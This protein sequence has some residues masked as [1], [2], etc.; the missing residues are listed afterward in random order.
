[1]KN[2]ALLG[3]IYSENKRIVHYTQSRGRRRRNAITILSKLQ[4]SL[5]VQSAR[6]NPTAAW[7]TMLIPVLYSVTQQRGH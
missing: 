6:R 2:E 4:V 3:V 5:Q 7:N 1:M